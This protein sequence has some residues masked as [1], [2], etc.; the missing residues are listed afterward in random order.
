MPVLVI[1]IVLVII[2]IINRVVANYGGFY[3]RQS[4]TV[5]CTIITISLLLVLV[6]FCK[7]HLTISEIIWMN[8]RHTRTLGMVDNCC[9]NL[10]DKSRK[11]S[12]NSSCS[13]VSLF[14]FSMKSI[15]V[16]KWHSFPST[17]PSQPSWNHDTLYP[18]SDSV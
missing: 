7:C 5:T 11:I 8:I 17:S 9:V 3:G 12:N 16:Q 18:Q 6:C 1:V 2:T 14:S 15:D 4:K 13:C 10:S